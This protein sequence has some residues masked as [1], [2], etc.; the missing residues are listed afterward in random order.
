MRIPRPGYSTSTSPTEPNPYCCGMGNAG[1]LPKKA[2]ETTAATTLATTT[3]EKEATDSDPRI[4]SSA[5]KAPASGALNAALIA[6]P[7]AHPTKMLTRSGV[8]RNA[9]PSHEPIAA[10]ST[11]TGPSLPADPPPPIVM[12]LASVRASAGRTGTS[13][14]L[15]TTASCTSGTF[16]P[17]CPPPR[18]RMINHANAMLAPVTIGRY[19]RRAVCGKATADHRKNAAKARSMAR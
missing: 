7:L 17:S 15:R 16:M 6:A 5:K 9:R 11:T 18:R 3:G 14:P 4:S 1:W 12:A 2:R 10:P 13:P 19:A 8:N